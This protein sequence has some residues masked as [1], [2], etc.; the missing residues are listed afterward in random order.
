MCSSVDCQGGDRWQRRGRTNQ[1]RLFLALIVTVTI[2]AVEVVGGWL[3]GSLALTSDGGHMLADGFALLLS[4]FAVRFAALP[5]T[6]EKTFGYYRLEI[7]SALANGILLSLVAVLVLI[8]AWS[9]LFAPHAVNSTAMLQIAIV[10]LV[11]NL[12]SVWI[13]HGSSH[14]LNVRGA[15]LHVLADT[16]SSLGVI[17]GAVAIAVTG[18]PRI[19]PLI[20]ALIAGFILWSSQRLV[21]DAVDV[22]LEAIPKDI[23][24]VDVNRAIMATDGVIGVHDLHIWSLTTGVEALSAHVLVRPKDLPRTDAILGDINR[25]LL[26]R[27]RIDHTTLQVESD[28]TIHGAGDPGAARRAAPDPRSHPPDPMSRRPDPTAGRDPVAR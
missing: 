2:C 5:A 27:F 21:R 17:V 8:E 19:D 9:R 6:A 13:L 12:I 14:N 24:V 15:Y 23:R 22:L 3:S 25:T 20:G 7:L 18:Q 10:G 1:R 26:E 11:A 4:L 28:A 16:A